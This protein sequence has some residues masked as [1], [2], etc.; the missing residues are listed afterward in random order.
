MGNILWLASYPKSGN[1]WMRAFIENYLQN[2]PHPVDIN[3]LIGSSTAEARADRYQPY[4]GDGKKT[5]DLS[6]EDICAIRPLVQADIARQASATVFVKTHNFLGEY[7]GFPLHNSSVTSGAIYMVR[8]PLDVAVSTANYFDYPIDEAIAY[9][10]EDMTGTPNELANVPQVISSWS[11]HV[12]SWTGNPENRV[13][14]LRYEDMLLNPLKEFRKVTSFLGLAKDPK[15]LKKA[16]GFS[17]FDQLKAQEKKHGFGERHENAR[18]FFRR[19]RKNQWR[20]KLTDRQVQRIVD[21]HGEQMARFK[22]LP[23][24]YS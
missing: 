15:R 17:S 3:Q 22:Y 11:A 9:M 23:A 4:V 6:I 18:S 1:T 19:G 13:L 10:A 14:V 21:D 5:T 20:E 12:Q 16:V 24:A 2:L 8:N 7:K